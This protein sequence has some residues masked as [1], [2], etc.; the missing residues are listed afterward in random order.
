MSVKTPQKKPETAAALAA[1]AYVVIG[2]VGRPHGLAGAF[3]VSGRDGTIDPQYGE[4]RIGPTLAKAQSTRIESSATQAGRPLLKCSLASDRTAASLL[5][6]C[7][8][9]AEKRKIEA[10]SG[11][12]MLWSDI[13]GAEVVDCD[14]EVLG[15]VHHVYNAGSSDIAEVS[16]NNRSVDIPLIADYLAADKPLVKSEHGRHRLRLRVPASVFLDV[17]NDQ[18]ANRDKA[19]V[20]DA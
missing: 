1:N 18:T 3:F 17:W 15:R 7:L 6:G 13:E 14:G 16:A 4:L 5:T 20:S 2:Q 10:R 11:N 19:D 12:E 8:I 9:F